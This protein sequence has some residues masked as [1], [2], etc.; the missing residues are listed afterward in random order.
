M[1]EW[2]RDRRKAERY[3]QMYPKGTRIELIRMGDDP[4]P[5][6]PGTR[7][8]VAFVD[9]MGQIGMHWDNGS[10]LSLIPGEDSFRVLNQ[11]EIASE[12]NAAS[13]ETVGPTLT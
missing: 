11:E 8:T 9:D 3:K 12:K 4:R 6:P 1:N 10:S 2:E 5:V 13:F 7:G